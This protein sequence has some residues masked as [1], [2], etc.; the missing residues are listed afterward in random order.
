MTKLRVWWIPQIPGIPFYVPVKS[1]EEGALVMET[2]ANYDLFQ[3]EHNIKPD[4]CNAGGLQMLVVDEETA[5][6]PEQWE[7]WYDEETGIED[8]VEWVENGKCDA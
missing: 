1:V 3:L 5:C 4:F 7:D 2:L 6:G 8:P